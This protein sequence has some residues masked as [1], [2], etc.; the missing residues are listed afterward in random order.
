MKRTW[1]PVTFWLVCCVGVLHAQPTITSVTNESGESFLCPGGVAFV[2]G[3]GLGTSPSIAVTVGSKQAFV[4]NA[5]GS[6]LQVELPT[7]A[8]QGATT[9]KAGASAPFNI[10]LG[11][12]CPGMPSNNVNGV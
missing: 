6:S 4:I 3:T 1:L 12:Y 10:T 2:R 5:F 8:P 11:Q 9:I 7:D